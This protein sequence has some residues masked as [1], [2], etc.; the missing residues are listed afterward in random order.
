MDG[1]T[2]YATPAEPHWLTCATGLKA[3][4]VMEM[5]G[6][7]GWSK[8]IKANAFF[9]D[10]Y[11]IHETG[12]KLYHSDSEHRSVID[13]PGNV[14]EDG[15]A[16]D[17]LMW[18]SQVNGRVTRIDLHKM[19]GPPELARHRMIELRRAWKRGKVD[20]AIKRFEF[21]GNDEGWTWY[22]G[23]RTSPLRLRTYDRRGPLRLE[24]QWRPTDRD[25]L[26]AQVLLKDIEAAWRMLA[27]K[28]VFELPWYKALLQGPVANFA[29]EAR[30]SD[31]QRAAQ[32]L[33][34]Q[35][36]V[37]L[38]MLDLLGIDVQQ[39][40]IAATEDTNRKTLAKALLWSQQAGEDGRALREIIT[41]LIEARRA[42][43]RGRASPEN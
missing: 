43:R 23:G 13:I 40:Q 30:E 15:W 28:I 34:T 41:P 6:E 9:C 2:L 26:L 5:L 20:T 31:W 16:N 42:R 27:S 24:F 21:Q 12:A 8:P 37:T 11:R 25:G 19:I 32:E 3:E 35:Y 14:C 1:P 29:V 22:F 17:W 36:G 10:G 7:G 38:W 33:K 18:S 39:L 4:T